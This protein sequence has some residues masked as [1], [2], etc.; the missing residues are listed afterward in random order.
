M[1]EL[2]D[3]AQALQEWSAVFARRTMRE[4]M[5]F[6]HN[7]ELSM[8]QINVLMRLYYRGPTEMVVLRRDMYGSRAA[9]TQLVEKLFQLGLVERVES[10]EDR[11]VKVVSLTEKGRQLVTDGVAARRLWLQALA[12]E[13]SREQQLAYTQALRTMTQVAVELEQ[14]ES[15]S[16]EEP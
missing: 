10:N 7:F 14:K 5:Q 3:F 15:S 13:L 8:P 16:V 9:A 2:T 12:G 11:R 4:F 6:A 1:D